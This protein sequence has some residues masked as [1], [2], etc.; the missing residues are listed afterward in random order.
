[1][2]FPCCRMVWSH[3]PQEA[4]SHAASL[5][6]SL[7][8]LREQHGAIVRERGRATETAAAAAAGAVASASDWRARAG[9]E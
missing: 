9:G 1:M 6:A 3:C 5:E 8:S 4:R 2:T 7:A